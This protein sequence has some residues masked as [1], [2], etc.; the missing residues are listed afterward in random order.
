MPVIGGA[1][2]MSASSSAG[3]GG[4]DRLERRTVGRR[5]AAGSGD[6]PRGEIAPVRE[7]RWQGRLDFCG[8]ELKQPVRVDRLRTHRAAGRAVSS[9]VGGASGASSRIR[10]PWGVRRRRAGTA[11]IAMDRVIWAPRDRA[12]FPPGSAGHALF[13][14][15]GLRLGL[16]PA[17]ASPDPPDDSGRPGSAGLRAYPSQPRPRKRPRASR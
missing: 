11:S 7:R 17:R 14:V 9:A 13:R 5:H 10:W 1:A 12:S 16:R 8:A 15:L 6:I 4:L 2:A 3:G